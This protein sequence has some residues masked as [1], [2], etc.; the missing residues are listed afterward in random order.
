MSPLRKTLSMTKHYSKKCN[1]GIIYELLLRYISRGVICNDLREI[2]K[3]VQIIRNHFHPGTELYRELRL[4]NTMIK[5]TTSSDDV[6][7]TIIKESRLLAKSM[8]SVN[9]DR[10]KSLLVWNINQQIDDPTFYQQKIP[11]YQMYVIVQDLLDDWRDNVRTN[12]VR[13]A[14]HENKIHDWLLQEKIELNLDEMSRIDAD[15]LVVKIMSEKLNDRYSQKL[16]TEQKKIIRLYT[17]MTHRN[18]QQELVSFLDGI[19]TKVLAD[20]DSYLLTENNEILNEK[21]D[22]VKARIQAISLNEINDETISRFL[23]ISK[24]KDE[25]LEEDR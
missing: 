19:R 23:T 16:S 9:L 25:L 3:A 2:R 21:A 10:E 11:E 17:L 7:W 5:T 24:L 4:F 15:A 12:I 18:E 13:M 8:N 14:E 20:L 1:I 22:Q 6:A